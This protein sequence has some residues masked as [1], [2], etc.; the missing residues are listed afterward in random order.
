MP[1]GLS[2]D[3]IVAPGHS[4]FR[5]MKCFCRCRCPRC[6]R[7]RCHRPRRPLPLSPPPLGRR[8]RC[9]PSASPA[10]PPPSAA[11]TDVFPRPLPLSP[12]DR[13]RCLPSADEAVP[14]GRCRRATL[15]SN[16]KSRRS[17]DPANQKNCQP[18]SPT[19]P[20]SLIFLP[21]SN[22]KWRMIPMIKGNLDF[23]L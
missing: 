6:R 10:V 17:R 20:P 14:L 7:H 19:S 2:E 12:F 8:H 9:F 16:Q 18:T 21:F 22:A 4:L 15:R 11:A 3:P 1:I 23:K 13:S 5:P